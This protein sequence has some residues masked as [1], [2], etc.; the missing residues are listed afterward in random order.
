MLPLGVAQVWGEGQEGPQ[1]LRIELLGGF[2]PLCVSPSTHVGCQAY[3]NCDVTLVFWEY[4]NQYT[5]R[6][7]I[8]VVSP[9][10]GGHRGGRSVIRALHASV[11]A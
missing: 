9:R 1:L 2:R 8:G 5:T 10:V 11:E 3:V 4:V 6:R 7:W